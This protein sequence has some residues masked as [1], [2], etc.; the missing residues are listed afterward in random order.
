M[1]L[2]LLRMLRLI[3]VAIRLMGGWHLIG[4]VRSTLATGGIE[5]L[6]TQ[7]CGR[8]LICHSTRHELSLALMFFALPKCALRLGKQAQPNR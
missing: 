5:A 1:S 7:S 4:M 8:R 2:S 6:L 3:P